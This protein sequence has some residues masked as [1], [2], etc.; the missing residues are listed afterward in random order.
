VKL[1]AVLT[2]KL[3]TLFSVKDSFVITG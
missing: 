3:K 1:F 2:V